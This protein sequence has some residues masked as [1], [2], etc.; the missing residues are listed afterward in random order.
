MHLLILEVSPRI[1]FWLWSYYFFV[2]IFFLMLTIFKDFIEC[3][4][5]L[6]LFYV[7]V[8]QPWDMWDR[9]PPTRDPTLSPC[10]GMQS[11]NHWTTQGSPLLFL[12]IFLLYFVNF[13]F[14]ISLYLLYFS[15]SLTYSPFI[16]HL[17]LFLVELWI[18]LN[19]WLYLQLINT[20]VYT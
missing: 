9:S 5:I 20:Y 17:S 12:F 8:F 2:K 7:S 4:T 3:V 6:L 18:F 19:P 13:Y 11:L 14:C 16:I 15:I 10:T 1:N